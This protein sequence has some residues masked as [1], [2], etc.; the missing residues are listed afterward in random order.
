MTIEKG[1]PWGSAVDRPD[2]LLVVPSDAALAEALV[3]DP[4]RPVGLSGGDLH[5]SLGS[6][7]PR[8]D[9]QRL[10]IDLIRCRVGERTVVAAAHVVMRS[11]WWRGPIV[12]VMNVDHLGDWNV[13]PRAHPNDGRVDVVEVAPSMTMRERWQA[14]SRLPGGTHVPHPAI[15]TG[16]VRE[17]SWE[18][19]RSLTVWAD[20]LRV[21]T[22]STV[23]IEVVPDAG[24]VYI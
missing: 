18:F 15:T 2:D 4:G 10:P 1:Q 7:P 6:P 17:R 11:G 19:E 16:S 5:R 3:A 9:M 21:G 14:R 13:A 8:N 24:A 20:G 23:S 12:A 22:A